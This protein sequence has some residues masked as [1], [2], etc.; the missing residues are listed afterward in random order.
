MWQP[1]ES[2]IIQEHPRDA[3][4]MFTDAR[5]MQ[6]RTDARSL[7]LWEQ[8]LSECVASQPSRSSFSTR[9]VEDST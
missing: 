1:F 3:Q 4:A 8:R 6:A 5:F 2:W 7:R 9:R